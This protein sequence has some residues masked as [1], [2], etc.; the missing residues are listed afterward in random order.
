MVK[1]LDIT[2]EATRK[3]QIKTPMRCSFTAMRAV[4]VGV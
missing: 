3:M 1:I 2:E 4:R